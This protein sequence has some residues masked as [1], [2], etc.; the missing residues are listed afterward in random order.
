MQQFAFPLDICVGV[1]TQFAGAEGVSRAREN[2]NERKCVGKIGP[3]TAIGFIVESLTGLLAQ[4]SRVDS[5]RRRIFGDSS[6]GIE[7]AAL[8]SHISALTLFRESG[9]A[10]AKHRK[11]DECEA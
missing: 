1:H 4:L 10:T 3:S 11:H 9:K 8:A 6:V 2:E 7:T 5:L